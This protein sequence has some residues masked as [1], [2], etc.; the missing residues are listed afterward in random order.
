MRFGTA[1]ECNGAGNAVGG[2]ARTGA[3]LK[4]VDQVLD[5]DTVSLNVTSNSSMH[6]LLQ[7]SRLSGALGR[8]DSSVYSVLFAHSNARHLTRSHSERQRD[9]QSLIAILL[10]TSYH[11][12]MATRIMPVKLYYEFEMDVTRYVVMLMMYYDV[13]KLTTQWNE[14]MLIERESMADAMTCTCSSMFVFTIKI[15]PI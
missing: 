10:P 7:L 13:S 1:S 4:S 3:F 6:D 5:L 15:V 8:L 12:L 2:S 9:T 11:V 14:L